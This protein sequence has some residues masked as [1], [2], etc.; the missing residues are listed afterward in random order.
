MVF[1]FFL[2]T[3]SEHLLTRLLLYCIS[4]HT[5]L[6]Q[7]IMST[8]PS[9][10]YNVMLCPAKFLFLKNALSNVGGSKTPTHTQKQVV[11]ANMLHWP[12]VAH[13]QQTLNK[14]YFAGL[15]LFERTDSSAFRLN[16]KFDR[17]SVF[18]ICIY[19]KSATTS[20]VTNEKRPV[21]EVQTQHTFWPDQSRCEVGVNVGLLVS[22]SYRN[23]R[24]LPHYLII[25]S[26]LICS[27]KYTTKSCRFC[28]FDCVTCHTASPGPRQ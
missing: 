3:C 24:T 28:H 27:W 9:A 20:Y 12:T 17:W 25:I 14:R 4:G 16:E 18:T 1:L 10:C 8:C 5:G 22:E 6:F 21:R 23:G 11:M 26:D 7:H 13:N 19:S 2:N 15:S